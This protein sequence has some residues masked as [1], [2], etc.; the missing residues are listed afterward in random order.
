MTAGLV[1]ILGI[2]TWTGALILAGIIANV[3]LLVC[4]NEERRLAAVRERIQRRNR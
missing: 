1:G 2:V 4:K 3:Y